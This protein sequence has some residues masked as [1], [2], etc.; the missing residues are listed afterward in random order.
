[1]K[2][3]TIRYGNRGCGKSLFIL[4]ECGKFISMI[5]ECGTCLH[6]VTYENKCIRYSP[7]YIIDTFSDCDACDEWEEKKNG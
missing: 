5:K 7:H 1:M 4:K 3:Y 2:E 6:F